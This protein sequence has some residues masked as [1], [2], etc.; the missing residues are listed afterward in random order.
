MK[1]I[2]AQ[3][4]RQLQKEEEERIKEQKA[5]ARAKLEEL[6]RRSTVVPASNAE[7]PTVVEVPKTTIE[8]EEAQQAEEIPAAEAE[9]VLQSGSSTGSTKRG[10][11]NEHG[12]RE[13]DRK[14]NGRKAGVGEAAKA[15]VNGI[16]S[17]ASAILPPPVATAAPLLT[18]PMP[19][20]EV[21]GSH[22]N[23]QRESRHRGRPEKKQLV[24]K[25]EDADR[26]V[27]AGATLDIPPPAAANGGWNMDSPLAP[28]EMDAANMSHLTTSGTEGSGSL[29]KSKNSRNSRNRP[30][31]EADRVPIMA[32]SIQF[33]DIVSGLHIPA[34]HTIVGGEQAV[35]PAAGVFHVDVGKDNSNV[36]LSGDALTGDEGSAVSTNGDA[37]SKRMQRKSRGARRGPA[38]SER[39]SQDQR[40]GE[41]SHASD[42]MVWAPV[43]SPGAAGGNKGEG[44]HFNEQQKEE[45][46]SAQQQARAKRAEMERYTPKPLMKYQETSDQPA[47]PPAHQH[48]QGS[49]NSSWQGAV[50]TPATAAESP[51]V[52]SLAE[53]KQVPSADPKPNHDTRPIESGTKGG[54]SH[55]SWRQRGS[56]SERATESSK[57][58]PAAVN[59]TGPA[60][61]DSGHPR[62]RSEQ[63]SA[64][65]QAPSRRNQSASDHVP[66]TPQTTPVAPAPAPAPSPAPASVQ[67]SEREHPADKKLYQPPRPASAPAHR[68]QDHRVQD[69]RGQDNRGQDYRGHDH[70]GQGPHPSEQKGHDQ[71]TAP[72]SRH[73][74]APSDRPLPS[75]NTGSQQQHRN[76]GG[77]HPRGQNVEKEQAPSQQAYMAPHAQQKPHPTAGAKEPSHPVSRERE[78]QQ[79]QS[80]WGSSQQSAE[81]GDHGSHHRG[82]FER[83]QAAR[84]SSGSQRGQSHWQQTGASEGF[85]GAPSRGHPTERDLAVTPQF[86]RMEVSKQQAPEPQR[87]QQQVEQAGQ[88]QNKAPQQAAPVA[89][90]SPKVDSGNWEGAGG[91]PPVMRGRD[92]SHGGRRG[93]FGGRSGPR[94]MEM[95]HRRDP[96]STKQRLVID[97]TGGAV[98]SQVGG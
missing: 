92:Y 52:G 2:A 31:A 88:Q 53:N 17:Q 93:R 48:T 34:F 87:P 16:P 68:G 75:E 38:R 84:P 13:R 89:I 18:T 81:S 71:G 33:G 82:R 78:P 8:A 29:R 40:A 14:A 42:S 60:H 6:D 26:C 47:A 97:A 64:G 62:H 23:A 46:S 41:K 74:N 21:Y 54:R 3:R 19:V 56:G 91:S 27:P 32:E 28:Q 95:E 5:K 73:S 69:Y 7:E 90:P 25:G 58:A 22:A 70:R 61:G 12:K 4:A 79:Q 65:G 57:D 85:R 30:R 49:Q 72:H 39:G 76:G 51:R 43:R 98:P 20:P 94:N 37:S 15:K 35:D 11:R 36:S 66:S 77:H 24:A 10:V 80:S 83:D 45:S 9:P 1:E 50:P 67:V 59:S 55:G 44:P 96:P 86:G 63:K